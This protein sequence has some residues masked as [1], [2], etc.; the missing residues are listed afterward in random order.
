[1]FKKRIAI[2]ITL[3]IPA[4]LLLLHACDDK[5]DEADECEKTKW[6]QAIQVNVIPR[7]RVFGDNINDYDLKDAKLITYHGSITKYYCKD[8][9]SQTFN[10]SMREFYPEFIEDENW[11]GGFY[12]GDAYGFKFQNDEDYL[13]V[14]LSFEAIFDSFT[15]YCAFVRFKVKHGDIFRSIDDLREFYYV[16]LTD[17]LGWTYCK[18]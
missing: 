2:I 6:D 18:K 5:E 16:D 4:M 1:M 8:N 15:S 10:Y 14:F 3:I 13:Q 9:P 7:V 12:I 17:D 11:A